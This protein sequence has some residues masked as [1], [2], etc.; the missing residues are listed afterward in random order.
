M[1]LLSLG[2]RKRTGMAAVAMR[3]ERAAPK[4]PRIDKLPPMLAC[5]AASFLP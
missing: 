2:V 1:L 3:L 5:R 4:Q